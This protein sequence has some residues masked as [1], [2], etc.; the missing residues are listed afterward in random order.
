MI[1]WL[2]L[3]AAFLAVS[4]IFDSWNWSWVIFAVGG[5]LTPVVAEFDKMIK[6]KSK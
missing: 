1:Y 6:R 4:F 3:V 2:V 5:V